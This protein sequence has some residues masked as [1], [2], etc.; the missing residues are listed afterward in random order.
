MPTL[1]TIQ[2]TP[3]RTIEEEISAFYI[4]AMTPSDLPYKSFDEYMN[5]Y[6][7]MDRNFLNLGSLQDTE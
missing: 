1:T 6:D 4:D 7:F 2:T 3:Y 5:T